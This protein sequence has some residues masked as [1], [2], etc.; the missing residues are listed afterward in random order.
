[1]EYRLTIIKDDN[2]FEAWLSDD[3]YD[4]HVKFNVANIIGDYIEIRRTEQGKRGRPKICYDLDKHIFGC[5]FGE[6]SEF[7]YPDWIELRYKDVKHSFQFLQRAKF[8]L[9]DSGLS[10]KKRATEI[11]TLRKRYG[12]HLNFQATYRNDQKNED[13]IINRPTTVIDYTDIKHRNT[14]FTYFCST[15]L[16][17][18]VAIIH[19]YAI[20]GFKLARCHHC[21]RYFA[22]QK[23]KQKYCRRISGYKNSF[24][25]KDSR[26]EVCEVTVRRELQFLRATKDRLLNQIKNSSDVLRGYSEDEYNKIVNE[27]ARHMK[28]VEQA[29]TTKN[30]TEFNKYLD[31]TKRNKEWKK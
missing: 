11:D 15:A 21:K 8:I 6:I 5:L 31:A 12:A 30:L 17:M 16:D 7:E 10:N 1:M 2:V 29:P 28:L 20:Y 4:R 25:Q 14:R 27:C 3:K 9:S 23:L 24:S 19:Y 18:V 13:E 26:A 22:T